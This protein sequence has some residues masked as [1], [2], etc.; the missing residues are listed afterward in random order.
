MS[1]TFCYIWTSGNK[2]Q[3]TLAK[4]SCTLIVATGLTPERTLIRDLA[5]GKNLP[6][7]L[8]LSGNFDHIHDFVDAVTREAL[9]LGKALATT[10]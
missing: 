2:R 10:M 8:H 9:D 3:D 7:W 6:D 5:D 4:F 1:K